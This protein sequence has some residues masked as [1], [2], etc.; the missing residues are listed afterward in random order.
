MEKKII[1]NKAVMREKKK[2]QGR[3]IMEKKIQNGKEHVDKSLFIDYEILR[4]FIYMVK[5]FQ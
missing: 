2:K 5:R 1:N 4:K 3:K